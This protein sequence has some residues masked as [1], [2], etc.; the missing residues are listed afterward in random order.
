VSLLALAVFLDLIGTIVHSICVG[1][2]VE[3]SREKGFGALPDICFKS[4]PPGSA[5][6][7]FVMYEIHLKRGLEMSNDPHSVN[8]TR[9]GKSMVCFQTSHLKFPDFTIVRQKYVNVP[10]RPQLSVGVLYK[11]QVVSAHHE[12]LAMEFVDHTTNES[13]HIGFFSSAEK[14]LRDGYFDTHVRR[15]E[16][17]VVQQHTMFDFSTGFSQDIGKAYEV[18]SLGTT[19]NIH[20]NCSR[21]AAGEPFMWAGNQPDIFWFAPFPDGAAVGPCSDDWKLVNVILKFPDD[22]VKVEVH[23]GVAM[24]II[25]TCSGVGGMMSFAA[26]LYFC[27]F[28]KKNEKHDIARI[29]NQRT[30]IGGKWLPS[31]SESL[32]REGSNDSDLESRQRGLLQNC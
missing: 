11:S 32:G 7:K 20:V 29:Y 30:F 12:G 2:S 17:K 3:Y 25:K 28:I 14:S 26:G 10:A 24:Q 1:P 15:V 19:K 23:T 27:M 8:V 6:V 5:N 4:D 18:G 9:K 22:S 13:Q 16:K 21:L 31:A